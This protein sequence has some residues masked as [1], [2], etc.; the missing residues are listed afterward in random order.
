MTCR[1]CIHY[2]ICMLSHDEDDYKKCYHFKNMVDVIEIDEVAKILADVTEI[3]PCEMASNE[4]LF[5]CCECIGYCGEI[6]DVECWEQYLKHLK[7]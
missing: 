1:D 6:S 7:R 2:D 5:D 3:A 4:W